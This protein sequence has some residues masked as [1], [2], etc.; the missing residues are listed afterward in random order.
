MASV[1][2]DPHIY[3]IFTRSSESNV[4]DTKY[5]TEEDIMKLRNNSSWST[6][7]FDA[8]ISMAST[9]RAE[10]VSYAR[11]FEV[12]FATIHNKPVMP[13]SVPLFCHDVFKDGRRTPDSKKI[14]N[15]HLLSIKDAIEANDID[16][17]GLLV[18][19]ADLFANH[20]KMIASGS[21]AAITAVKR[22]Y[23]DYYAMVMLHENPM[24]RAF[25]ETINVKLLEDLENIINN[26]G[27]DT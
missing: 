13:V 15:R 9:M 21:L 7:Y 2:S 14:W 8:H 11:P 5:V 23:P 12:V 27:V 16:Q 20:G 6:A 18:G 24:S 19:R 17:L 26:V 25:P 3:P 22:Q 4:C 10:Y 1:R